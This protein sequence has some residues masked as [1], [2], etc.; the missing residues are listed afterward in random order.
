MKLSEEFNK[1]CNEEVE[2]G[3]IDINTEEML[4]KDLSIFYTFMKG[5]E[6]QIEKMRNC[7]N[8]KN[9]TH[10]DITYYK[11]RY[12]ICD[13]CFNSDNKCNWELAG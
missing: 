4:R 8:C 13:P 9:H 6:A 3:N 5:M 1:W 10:S 12:K 2:F 11:E 7:N